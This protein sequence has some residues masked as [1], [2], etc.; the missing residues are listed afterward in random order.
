MHERLIAPRRRLLLLLLS[1]LLSACCPYRHSETPRSGPRL[2]EVA[3]FSRAATGVAV[4]PD[5]RT[6]VNFPNWWSQPPAAVVELRPGGARVPVPDARWNRW[7]GTSAG[8]K[9]AFVCVQSVYVDRGGRTLWILDAANPLRAIGRK[10]VRGAA[11]LVRVDVAS[12]RVERVYRFGLDVAPEGSYLNDVRID[13]A[14]GVAYISESEIGALI[15]L[16]LQSGRARRLL[17]GHA[18]TRAEP[19]FT[20]TVGGRP[21][22]IFGLSAPRIHADGIALD[23]RGEWLY[24]HAVSGKTLYRVR[25]ADLRDASLGK[26]ALAARVQ[27]LGVTGAADGMLMGPRGTLYLTALEQDAVTA[28]APSGAL[29]VLAQDPRLQ[30]PDSLALRPLPGGGAVLYVTVT[31]IHLDWPFNFGM[32]RRAAPYRLFSLRLPAARQR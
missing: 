16:D 19:G 9:N 3:R 15:V 11:K 2:V 5:G 17:D 30:W 13:R 20:P 10:L 1:L 27:R 7:D 26:Q 8:A 24:Y 4:A 6:F 29:R 12:R 23:P 31:M 21:W 22:L 18:S 25:T 14:R 28:R 32:H